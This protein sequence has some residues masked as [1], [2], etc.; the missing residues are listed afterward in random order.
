MVQDTDLW[1][2]SNKFL[3]MG[4]TETADE[5]A[6]MSEMAVQLGLAMGGTATESMEN[7][8]LMMANQS[9]PRLDSFGISSGEARKRI[10]EL[11]ATVGMTQDDIDEGISDTTKTI[12]ELQDK[13][14]LAT[15]KEQEFTETTSLSRRESSRLK[16]EAMQKEV[17]GSEAYLNVLNN[18]TAAEEA[19]SREDAFAQVVMEMGAEKMAL[20]GDQADTTTGSL[21]KMEAAQANLR[22]GIGQGFIPVLDSLLAAGAPIAT[23]LGEEIPKVAAIAGEIINEKLGVLIEKVSDIWQEVWPEA[24]EIVLDFWDRIQPALV[25]LEEFWDNFVETLMPHFQTAW[26]IFRELW[27]VLVEVWYNDLRPALEELWESL[28]FGT[29]DFEELGGSTGD[30]LGMLIELV[31]SVVMVDLIAGIKAFADVILLV[32]DGIEKAKIAIA[33]IKE[34]FAGWKEN[35]DNIR[36]AFGKLKLPDWLTPGSATPLELGLLGIG[37]AMKTLPTLGVQ[38]GFGDRSM[39]A[40][41]RGALEDRGPVSTYYLTAHYPPQRETSLVQDIRLLQMLTG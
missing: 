34:T 37:A 24:K 19:M 28:G 29:T 36:D 12:E 30:F 13:I 26:D 38:V 16:I 27:D 5:T 11:T 22:Y 25:K 3:L 14:Y 1:Y 4:L 35:I 23:W 10:E 18:M 8:A 7:C 41:G 2:A 21:A 33:D 6:A 9:I 20:V 39:P 31:T 15:L 32:I 40:L 17:E